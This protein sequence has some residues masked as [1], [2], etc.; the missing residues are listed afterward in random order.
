LVDIAL[1]N[2][3]EIRELTY[4]Q[5]INKVQ[6]RI[7]L[8]E[9]LPNLS[10]F[11]GFNYNSKDFLYNN[12]WV[13]WGAQTSWDVFNAFKYPLKKRTVEV[14]GEYLD[15]R[16][17]ALTM[18]VVTQV[19]VSASQYEI[20]KR[21]LRT[22]SRFLD[23]NNNILTQIEL[24]HKARKVSYQTYV[25]ENMNNIVAEAKY[26]M[27]Y[28]ALQNS[29]ADIYTAVGQPVYGDV[30]AAQMSVD[31]LANHLATYWDNLNVQLITRENVNEHANEPSRVAAVT[32]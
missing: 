25:R 28:A 24:G 31:E 9:V 3:P 23:V 21:K 18:A 4:E 32:Q 7:A 30:N 16:A 26:D 2:R 12:S 10:F 19:H 15:Q 27:A 13:S 17:L 22:E 1:I 8:L 29:L 14:N 6:A 5:R 11:G 20:A